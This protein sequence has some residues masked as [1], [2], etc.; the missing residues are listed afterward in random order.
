MTKETKKWWEYNSRYYQETCKIPI[1][2]HYCPGAPNEAHLKLL[3]NVKGKK[4]L[5]IGC[6]GAQCG[7]YF[8]KQGAKVT[9]IDISTEQLKFAKALVKKNKV[10]IKLYKGDIRTLPQ[11]KSNSQDIV[12]SAYAL[13]Y[14]DNLESCFKEV[15]RVLKKNGIFVFSLD[16]PFWN[17]TDPKKLRI[18][19]SYF[20][21]GKYVEVFS[22][23]TKK[24]VAYTHKVSDFFNLLTEAGF[25]VEKII[26]P[27]SR[28]KYYH[29]VCYG[30][31]DYQPKIM[32]LIPPTI[33]FKARKK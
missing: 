1:D 26:E 13:H 33:I 21:T 30:L 20:N 7:I 2:A 12:F 3:G 4:L 11:I 22:D 19:K 14:V 5:E 10:N 15:H 31:W 24:F 9:G 23:K 25:L 18:K 8:A 17:I 32:N 27:D 16:H 29:D 6:G 28:K